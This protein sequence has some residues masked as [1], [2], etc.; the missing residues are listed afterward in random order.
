MNRSDEKRLEARQRHFI[1]GIVVMVLLCIVVSVAEFH[2]V[3]KQTR[4]KIGMIMRGTKDEDGWNK[5]QYE[6]LRDAAKELGMDVIVKENALRS[7]GD[8]KKI[9]DGFVAQGVQRVIVTWHRYPPELREFLRQYPNIEFILQTTEFSEDNM[10][11][12]STRLFEVQYLAGLIAGYQTETGV[13]GYVAPFSCVEVNRGLNAFTIGVKRANPSAHVK[14][15][16]SSDWNT[17]ERE[18]A[19]VESL[20]ME[21]VD[22]LSY[23]Q[24]GRT[25]ADAAE[26]KGIDYID[27]HEMHPEHRHCL[28][29]VQSDWKTVYH[30]ILSRHVRTGRMANANNYLWQG[31]LEQIVSVAPLSEWV[32]PKAREAIA[33][34]VRDRVKGEH[35]IYGGEIYDNNGVK[36]CDAKEIL[37]N[38]YLRVNM[39]WLV[40]GVEQVE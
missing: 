8:Y 17:P 2:T 5:V 12:C 38:E 19:A 31:F 24:D 34:S 3:P 6:G 28:T 21:D 30:N 15:A 32:K 39:N 26:K 35:L 27:A 11:S 22:V 33:R 14:V 1:L 25:V 37:S 9:I 16:W 7:I 29:A 20:A 18:R 10:V 40:K 4:P 36:R 23:Q 13:V